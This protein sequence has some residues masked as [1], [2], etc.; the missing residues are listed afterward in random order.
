MGEV[1]PGNGSA[2]RRSF[3]GRRIRRDRAGGRVAAH[4]LIDQI[5]DDGD[6]A[7]R[8]DARRAAARILGDR[9][10]RIF[11]AVGERKGSGQLEIE[12][13]RHQPGHVVGKDRAR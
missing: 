11:G 3:A 1:A 8:V 6:V 9:S 4:A 5:A 10:R 13:H 12:I 2:D 7:V